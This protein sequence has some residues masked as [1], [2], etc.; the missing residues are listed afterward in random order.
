MKYLL[1]L[2][3]AVLLFSCSTQ[4]S[5]S[6]YST[7]EY[8]AGACFG[9][10]PIYKMTIQADRTAV[11]EAEHFNFSKGTSKD[12]FSKPREGTF[13]TTIKEADYNKLVALLDGLDVKN[14]QDKYG[15]RNI[16][17]L[18]TSYLRIKFADGT[19]KNTEDYGKRGSEKLMKVYQF[20]EDLK[21]NQQW[22]KVK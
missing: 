22:T 1:G 19:S 18:P 21:Q 2:F 5:Q 20:F 3:A 8:E 12:E 6:K 4:K 16:S 14:L 15:S 7:I 9:F 10:C 17:D 11:L 13:T